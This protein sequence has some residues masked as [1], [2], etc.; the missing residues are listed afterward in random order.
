MR[1]TTGNGIAAILV[2]ALGMGLAVS[3]AAAQTP[4]LLGQQGRLFDSLGTPID[5][6]LEFTFTIY[7]DEYG[8]T[9]LWS[10][11]QTVTVDSGYYSTALGENTP[12]GAEVFNG[13]VRYLGIKVGADPEMTPLQPIMS[14]PYAIAADNVTGDIT[15]HSIT[16][17]GTLIIDASGN[18]VGPS[19]GLA[20]PTGPAGSTGP[21]GA[22][23]PTGAAGPA[24]P[25]GPAGAAGLAGPTGPAGA[26]GPAGPTGPAGAAGAAGPAGPTGPAGAAGAA[27]PAGP[28]GPQGLQGPAGTQGG[29]G[30]TGSQG[31]AGA[32][33]AAGPTGPQG[34]AG[35][36][37]WGLSGNDTY[38]TVGNV[39]IGT[40]V[41]GR[42]LD[43]RRDGEQ[44]LL[45]ILNGNVNGNAFY[46]ASNDAV[47]WSFGVSGGTQD[48]FHVRR[49]TEVRLAIEEANGNVGIGTTSPDAKLDVVGTVAATNYRLRECSDRIKLASYKTND[50]LGPVLDADY[51]GAAVCGAGWHVCNYQEATVYAVVFGCDNG[52]T[53]ESTWIVGGWRH[54]EYHRRSIWS[55]QDSVQCDSGRYP[56]WWASS[57]S[58]PYKGRVHCED[59][60]VSMRVSCCRN[61]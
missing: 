49:G 18:W 36:S 50:V 46:V 26:A 37:P 44:E 24:G 3:E 1:G 53:G 25:T 34:P 23:G 48:S 28:T 22:T 39:G 13:D 42:P 14:V 12:F 8:A 17:D 5:G 38:Y 21:A 41:P 40:A 60:S 58:A 6:Q 4:N 33:G 16:V 19:S 9:L 47:N 57:V 61:M 35:A 15:P 29:Q 30:P 11:V 43:I 10:E 56:A 7:A 2:A 31:P 45:R 54:T 52:A 27:G 59:S 20:G 55:G 32:A 51:T